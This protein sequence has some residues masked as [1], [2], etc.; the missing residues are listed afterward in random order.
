MDGGGV[1][2]GF[3]YWGLKTLPQTTHKQKAIHT[4]GEYVLLSAASA[5]DADPH[6]S[7]WTMHFDASPD[8]QRGLYRLLKKDPAVVRASMLKLGENLRGVSSGPERTVW[9]AN[10]TPVAKLGAK[11]TH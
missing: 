11:Q 4:R 9:P 6:D 10:A 8:N 7:Y 2:R 1:V 3:R 5:Y